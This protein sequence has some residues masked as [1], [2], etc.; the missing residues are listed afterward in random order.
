MQAYTA[1]IW[2]C[3]HF[4]FSL[5]KMDLRTR[6]KRSVLGIGW[7]LLHP[8]AMSTVLCVVFYKLFQVDILDFGPYLLSGLTFW[9][10][11]SSTISQGCECFYQGEKYIRQ[12]PAPL[13]I[14]PLRTVL[15]AAFHFGMALVLVIV[16]SWCFK[17]FGNLG[18]LAGL[19]PSLLLALV[20]GWALAVIAAFAAVFF[21]DMKHLQEIALQILFYATPVMYPAAMLRD[22]GMGWLVDYNPLGA[23]LDLLRKPILEGQIPSLTSYGV[24]FAFAGITTALATLMLVR[25]QKRLIFYL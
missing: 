5:V 4:W 22:R 25:L 7:S 21:P 20:F 18:A 10:F 15:G 13:A 8:I 2:R 17:G 19:V 3:R 23:M 24:V 16:L 1:A 11:L 12:Y 9:N 6:Y 14:Y